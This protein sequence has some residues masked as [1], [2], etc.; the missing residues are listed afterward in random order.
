MRRLLGGLLV[1]VLVLAVIPY[2]PLHATTY[3]SQPDGTTGLDTLMQSD[4]PTTNY[5]TSTTLNVGEHNA[6]TSKNRTL[7]FFDLSSIP[8]NATINSATLSLWQVSE[9][10][11]N[12]RTLRVYRDLRSWSESQATWNIFSTGNNWGTAGGF[13][14]SDA[15][16]TDIGSCAFTA[17]EAN[18]EKQWTL[19]ASAIQE[20]VSGAFANNGFVIKADTETDDL[21]RFRSS[22]DSTAAER[23]KLVIDYSEATHTPTNT[24]T[25]TA[26][27]TPTN[28]ATATDTPTNTATAT[29]TPT[30]TATATDTPTNT[31]TATD[32]PINTATATDTPINTAT[33]TDTPINTPT[34]TATPTITLTPSATTAGAYVY[35]LASG[36]TFMIDPEMTFGDIVRG[37]VLLFVALL[38]LVYVIY[39]VIERWA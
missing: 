35:Q 9:S 17:T 6:A 36:K 32:T 27:D 39:K 30:N 37:A 29:D 34:E 8:A 16:Q 11:S 26:T 24:A 31:A 38:I 3:S 33:A 25:F 4:N 13:N 20:M 2:A 28:T 19:T 14:A 10:S 23:P 21:F 5:G 1:V 12:A 18:G 15:E 7:I 22:D